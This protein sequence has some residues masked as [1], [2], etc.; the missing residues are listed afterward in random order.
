M[1]FSISNLVSLHSSC[2]VERTDFSLA[3]PDA[4]DRESWLCLIAHFDSPYPIWQYSS[5]TVSSGL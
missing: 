5:L 1:F 3:L 4:F 2:L